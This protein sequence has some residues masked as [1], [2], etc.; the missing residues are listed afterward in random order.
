WAL[1]YALFCSQ[2]VPEKHGG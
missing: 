1:I 2:V